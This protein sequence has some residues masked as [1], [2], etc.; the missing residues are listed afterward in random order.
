MVKLVIGA[1]ADAVVVGT[2]LVDKLANP[3]ACAE[4]MLSLRVVCHECT[5]P[6]LV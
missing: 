6:L 5:P 1:G 3:M 2:A 4:F